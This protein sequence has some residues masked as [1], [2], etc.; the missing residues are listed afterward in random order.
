M[1]NWIT[2]GVPA[3]TLSLALTGYLVLRHSAR[4]F[5]RKYGQHFPN[6]E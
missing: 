1:S 3:L 5:D 6:G 2:Y 4:Q